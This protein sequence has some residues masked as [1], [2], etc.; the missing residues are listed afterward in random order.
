MIKYYKITGLNNG[1]PIRTYYVA[2]DYS[3]PNDNTLE[4]S[5]LCYGDSSR[6]YEEVSKKEYEIGSELVEKQFI[7]ERMIYENDICE[8][9]GLPLKYLGSEI[10]DVEVE[11]EELAALLDEGVL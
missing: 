8:S 2:H 4:Y 3:D 1:E 9:N 7:L 10:Y 11:I 5:L 6:S